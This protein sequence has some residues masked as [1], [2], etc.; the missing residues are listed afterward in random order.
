MFLGVT[1][2]LTRG[3]GSYD[4]GGKTEEGNP[5]EIN[6]SHLLIDILCKAG[7]SREELEQKSLGDLAKDFAKLLKQEV[8]FDKE[9]LSGLKAFSMLLGFISTILAL[10]FAPLIIIQFIIGR[11]ILDIFYSLYLSFYDKSLN[12]NLGWLFGLLLNLIILPIHEMLHRIFYKRGGGIV[13]RIQFNSKFGGGIYAK[14]FPNHFEVNNK[15]KGACMI[16]LTL[17]K[18]IFGHLAN[19]LAPSLFQV[20]L[21]GIL[22]SL[23]FGFGNETIEIIGAMTLFCW[24]I[25]PLS[26]HF[27]AAKTLV[28][29]SELEELRKSSIKHIVGVRPDLA[30]VF[31]KIAFGDNFLPTISKEKRFSVVSR[32]IYTFLYHKKIIRYR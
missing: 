3:I 7:F 31:K 18:T 2:D 19:L 32:H 5:R 14:L 26:D 25:N 11:N 10:Y 28:F 9:K 22:L 23:G 6:V 13:S 15:V 16:Y 30:L 20:A 12:V 29:R 27:A 21:A 4:D 17:P 24:L 8:K 1:K